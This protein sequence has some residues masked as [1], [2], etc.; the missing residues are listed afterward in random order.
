MNG[1]IAALS[2]NSLYW[3]NNNID[4][5]LAGNDLS[6]NELITVASSISN[7]LVTSIGK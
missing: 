5:Y 4:Y 1:N 6:S 2:G 3:S 7:T